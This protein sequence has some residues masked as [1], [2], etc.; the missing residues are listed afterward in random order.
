VDIPEKELRERIA[1]AD[2]AVEA[3]LAGTDNGGQR[4]ELSVSASG[5][6][7]DVSRIRQLA[8]RARQSYVERGEQVPAH[9][10]K[11][12]TSTEGFLPNSSLEIVSPIHPLPEPSRERRTM[13]NVYEVLRRKEMELTRLKREVEA[14]RMVAPLLAD[15]GEPAPISGDESAL[16]PIL[17][18][19]W[20]H[21]SDD[22]P[23]GRSL[24]RR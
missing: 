4:V 20:I 5:C 11:A 24:A 1:I 3:L 9:V 13:K 21:E 23:A 22:Q 18:D 14:L 17:S 12:L 8:A 6:N 16:R 10:Q 19:G 15:C 2:R 7:D